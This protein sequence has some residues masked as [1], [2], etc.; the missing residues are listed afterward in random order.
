MLKEILSTGMQLNSLLFMVFLLACAI[1]YYVLPHK[2]RNG[3]LLAASYVFYCVNAWQYA[4]LLM[5]VTVLTYVAG[6]AI[7]RQQDEKK[8][9]ALLTGSIVLLLAVLAFFK[10][11][12]RPLALS[13]YSGGA[14][15]ESVL[16]KLILPVGISYYT[17]QIVGY[18]IDVHHK[19]IA[20]ETNIITYALFVSFF[21]QILAGPIGRASE[22]LPQYKEEHHFDSANIVEGCQRFLLGAFRKVVVADGLARIVS[23]VYGDLRE[24]TGLALVTA[25]LLFGLQLYADFAGYT[26]MA[27]GAA[28]ILGF[29]FR[30]NFKAPYLATNFTGFWQ[31]WHMSLTSWLNDYVF[32]PLV[33]SR[34]YNKLFF[35]KKADEH[36]PAVLANIMIVFLISGIWHGDTLNFVIWGVLQGVLRVGEELVLRARKKKGRKLKKQQSLPVVLAK[37][38]GI[39]LTWSLTLVFFRTATLSDAG[40]VFANLFRG[41]SF[42]LYKSD[43]FALIAGAP[44]YR[45]ST[46]N[47]YFFIVIF[48]LVV[49]AVLDRRIFA[50]NS[51]NN[52]LATVGKKGRWALY[53]AM[54][55]A[56]VLFYFMSLTAGMPPFIYA[57]H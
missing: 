31:R 57:G 49:T 36:K 32:T 20:P 25:V 42:V 45:I 11:V 3:F 16:V 35:G 29:E 1:I 22:L 19:K 44:E 51:S 37:R 23:G 34:W 33:W 52:A 10:Y 21:P 47:L 28:K 55:F 17:F 6:R 13:L 56:V 40:Y 41:T 39:Y 7:G 18:L 53:W 38:L 26:D 5:A 4:L 24:H 43:M 48:G 27:V 30:E 46:I 2:A 14:I 54:G 8:R 12:I 15:A 9:R 50:Q